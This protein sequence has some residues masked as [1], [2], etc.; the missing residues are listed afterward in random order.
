M[1]INIGIIG[2]GTVGS[3][4]VEAIE[5]NNLRFIKKYNIKINIC[6]I[7]AK[8]KNKKRSF[9]KTK[10]KWYKNP[11]ELINDSEIDLIV[12]LIG[13]ESGLALDIANK[14]L[15]NKK[16]LVTAN[17]A[18]LALHGSKLSTLAHKFNVNLNFEASVAGGIPIINIIQSS[19]LS[20]NIVNLY[21][22]LNG[23]CNYILSQM[24]EKKISFDKALKDAQEKG[25]AELDPY[26]DISG[27][28][29]AYKLL[30]LSNLVFGTKE[31]ITSVYKEG[32][33]GI[34]S[35]D[36][37]MAEKLGY[38]VTLLGITNIK[39]K[40]IQFR[41]HPCLVPKNS[42]I[43][44]VKNELNTVI[45][46]ADMSDKTVIIGKGAGKKPTASAV[47]SDILNINKP[48]YRVLNNRVK[49]DS[50]KKIN[51][52]ERK[53]KFYIRM[54]VLDSP[55]VLADIT[56]YFKKE[57]ISI[58]SM[59]QLERD[60]SDYVQLIFV[61]H[62]VIERQLILVVKKIEKIDKVK[63]K[64]KFIRIENNL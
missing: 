40:F 33:E 34:E 25:F 1:H 51:M 42:I 24:L 36:L 3:G 19:L 58:S 6:G 23:T 56:A 5:K 61:T 27:T 4:V 39:K 37:E 44:K 11:L 47:V 2:L 49:F 50:F 43:A 59:F 14:T 12:E 8:D 64:A 26:D 7:S 31:K 29:T 18:M 53:G 62:N 52:K 9:D 46:E 55:G 48:K 32:I 38:S 28:D 21:G 10:Y 63:T 15:K 60:K 20:D 35:I 41:V 13:G 30:I 45:I 57:K 54:E 17:K 22:I 16:H